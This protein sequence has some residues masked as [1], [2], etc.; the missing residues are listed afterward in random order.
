MTKRDIIH[1]IKSN[2]D[3]SKEY[4]RFIGYNKYVQCAYFYFYKKHNTGNIESCIRMFVEAF[5][6]K[7]W[8]K[9]EDIG[10]R[11]VKKANKL[12]FSTNEAIFEGLIYSFIINKKN[13]LVNE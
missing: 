4:E 1:F 3:N 11:V 2:I 5:S 8:K 10:L 9:Y 12:I 13:V 6:V 7:N